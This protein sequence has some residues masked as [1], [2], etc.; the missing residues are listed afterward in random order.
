MAAL[1]N[2]L[3]AINLPENTMKLGEAK[4]N[5]GNDMLKMMQYVFPIVTQ[6]QMEVIKKYGFSEGREG[7]VR[8]AQLIRTMEKDD[9]EVAHLHAQVR[10][11]FLPPVAISTED[12]S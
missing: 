11:H 5:A 8:F 6:I 3:E 4:D 1:T 12:A 7:I 10:A 2:V 9:A